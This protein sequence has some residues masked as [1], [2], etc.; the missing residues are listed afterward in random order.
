[1]KKKKYAQS[2]KTVHQTLSS[3]RADKW[4]SKQMILNLQEKH[5][6]KRY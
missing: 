6:S 5:C 2:P 3:L 1:M 4:V